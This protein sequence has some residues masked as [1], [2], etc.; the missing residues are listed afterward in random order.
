MRF[1]LT[2]LVILIS[3]ALITAI[4]NNNRRALY[5]AGKNVMKFIKKNNIWLSRFSLTDIDVL[6]YY[7][8]RN[9]Y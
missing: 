8:I 4:R 2:V 3:K 1:V 6:N 9:K 5:R 7:I